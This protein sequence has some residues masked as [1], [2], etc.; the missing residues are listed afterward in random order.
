MTILDLE[1]K[2]GTIPAFKDLKNL[3]NFILIDT[4]SQKIKDLKKKYKKNF[5]IHCLDYFVDKKSHSTV[6]KNLKF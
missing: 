5:N 3:Y 6:E 2:F 1:A 4:D